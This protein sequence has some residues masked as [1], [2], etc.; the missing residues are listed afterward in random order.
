MKTL[1]TA[2]LAWL[3]F[4][5]AQAGTIAIDSGAGLANNRTPETVAVLIHPAWAP[6]IGDAVWIS[7][8][9]TG[10][11]DAVFQPYIGL[12]PAMSVYHQFTSPEADLLLKVWADNTAEVFLDGISLMAP[13]FTEDVACTGQ[14]IGCRP[15]D[16]GL[17]TASLGAGAHTLRFDVYQ[18]AGAP[19]STGNPFGLL[20]SGVAAWEDQPVHTP[21]PG[22]F[23]LIGAAMVV[24]G[25]WRRK[26]A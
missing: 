14:P 19:N 8:A 18:F 1:T 17:I 21:E 26:R 9:A 3:I 4:S 11:K 15:Q 22:T 25:V 23:G 24:A 10:W 5:T 2:I 16:F 7:Y 6:N 20:Y 12:V 13:T